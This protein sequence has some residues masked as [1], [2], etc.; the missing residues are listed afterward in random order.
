[1]GKRRNFEQRP[2]RGSR[3]TNRPLNQYRDS[4][5]YVLFKL[6]VFVHMNIH[7]YRKEFF[8]LTLSLSVFVC[9]FLSLPL[10]N[11]IYT[12]CIQEHVQ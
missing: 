2:T 11:Y 5:S 3:L 9:L 7:L 10:L 8:L 1:M 4:I 6:R 12:K